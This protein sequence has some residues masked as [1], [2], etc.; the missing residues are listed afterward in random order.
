ML[1]LFSA[2]VNLPPMLQLGISLLLLL[3]FKEKSLLKLHCAAASQLSRAQLPQA[4]PRGLQ[5]LPQ[6]GV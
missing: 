2:V 1:S 6:Q 4:P 5:S 3:N